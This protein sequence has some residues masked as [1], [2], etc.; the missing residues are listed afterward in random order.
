[1][2]PI[3][4]LTNGHNFCFHSN[5]NLCS[6]FS[7]LFVVAAGVLDCGHHSKRNI[8]DSAM[9]LN[10]GTSLYNSLD[11][12][13]WED[14]ISPIHDSMNTLWSQ[15]CSPAAF[16]TNHTP[17]QVFYAPYTCMHTATKGPVHLI[18]A[19]T[20]P[21]SDLCTLYMHAHSDFVSEH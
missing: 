15:F 11:V 13:V 14:F 12:G 5:R 6:H 1:M 2:Q 21:Q 20:L 8:D 19:R 4:S 10:A 3:C 9:L 7:H 16:H 18:H 17:T